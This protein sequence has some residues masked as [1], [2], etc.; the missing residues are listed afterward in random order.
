MEPAAKVKYPSIILKRS[1]LGVKV[2]DKMRDMPREQ[3]IE[4]IRSL[5]ED[6]APAAPEPSEVAAPVFEPVP[7]VQHTVPKPSATQTAGAIG[8]SYVRKILASQ[9]EVLDT[10]RTPFSGDIHIRRR[11]KYGPDHVSI[12]IEVKNYTRVVPTDEDEKFKRDLTRLPG[13]HGAA[14]VCLNAPVQHHAPVELT[15]YHVGREMPILYLNSDQP[16]I[17]LAGVGLLFAHIDHKQMIYDHL[18]LFPRD[19]YPKIWRDATRALEVLNGISKS[20]IYLIEMRTAL[21]SHIDRIQTSILT[22]ESQLRELLDRIQTRVSKMLPDSLTGGESVSSATAWKHVMDMAR[23]EF[24]NTCLV[25]HGPNATV[26]HEKLVEF[27]LFKAE[28]IIVKWFKNIVNLNDIR[29]RLFVSKT[30]VCR[31]AQVDPN[32]HITVDPNTTYDGTWMTVFVG[33]K[34]EL[35]NPREKA[36]TG[37]VTV[38][39]I[40]LDTEEALPDDLDS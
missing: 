27:G 17:I 19:D 29:L 37:T 2:Y 23:R 36:P 21:C 28:T 20:R 4:R 34:G 8:E 11:R 3:L 40:S 9:Y 6:A 32:G 15:T 14:F 12:M 38:T 26:V 31:P 18:V 24:P 10:G 25:T 1:E 16:D 22:G 7:P 13:I 35:L 30:E 5:F 39:S 33:R